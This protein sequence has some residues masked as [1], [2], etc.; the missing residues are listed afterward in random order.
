MRRFG[1]TGKVFENAGV[2]FD[3]IECNQRTDSES[4]LAVD[5]DSIHSAYRLEIYHARRPRR[6]VFH[7][8]DQVLTAGDRSWRL[9][10]VF[11]E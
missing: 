3:L 1:E 10:D 4:A 5:R 11:T 6:V 7:R 9:I 2:F 8:C